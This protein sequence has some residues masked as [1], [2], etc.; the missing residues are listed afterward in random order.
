M[1]YNTLK[2]FFSLLSFFIIFGSQLNAQTISTEKSWEGILKITDKDSLKIVLTLKFQN[3]SLVG[4]EFDSP[5][6]F[7]YGIKTSSF[8]I[9]NDTLKVVAKQISA[10][11]IAVMNQNG[12]Y[13]GVF[14]QRNS[15]KKLLL[16]PI[17]ERPTLKRPQEPKPPYDYIETELVIKDGF[18]APLIKGTLTFPSKPLKGTVILIS[19]SGWQDRDETIFGHKPFKVIADYLTQA[20]YAVYRYDDRGTALFEKSTT[21]DFVSDVQLI[22]NYFKNDSKHNEHKIGLI[23][24]SEGG[25]VAFMAAAENPKIDFIITMAG[26]SE[27]FS[28]I[29]LYQAAI[30]AKADGFTDEEVKETVEISSKIYKMLS[31]VDSSAVAAAKYREIV[32]DYSKKMTPEQKIKYKLTDGDVLSQIGTITSPWFMN[33]FK[34]DPEQYLKKIECPVYALNGEKDLQVNYATN[35]PIIK[36][37]ISK[38]SPLSKV[39]SFPNLNH[40]FQECE[41]GLLNEYGKIEQTISPNVLNNILLWI[42]LVCK[43]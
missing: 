30:F 39:E 34:I 20:G 22:V 3:D 2:R 14:T 1:K 21:N 9:K 41:T 25:L 24:H 42:D 5:D 23:G 33:L 36:K 13:E 29:I 8:K 7:V 26:C 38:K 11:F 10:H 40:L 31:K 28:K 17:A 43:P 12:A 15:K 6:Q 32:A 35:L 37:Y 4:A 27:H 18:G 16:S 19:G